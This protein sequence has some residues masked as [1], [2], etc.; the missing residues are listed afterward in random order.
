LPTRAT[1]PRKESCIDDVDAAA[2]AAAGPPRGGNDTVATSTT[3]QS[4]GSS[5]S[6]ELAQ[7]M[8][9]EDR[10]DEDATA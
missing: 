8:V 1:E 10:Y 6:L 2:A 7:L 9:A 3:R 5:S 4:S